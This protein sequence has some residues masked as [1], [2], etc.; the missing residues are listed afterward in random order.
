MSVE[1]L[2]PRQAARSHAG[3]VAQRRLAVFSSRAL[4]GAGLRE[5]APAG[6]WVAARVLTDPVQ[7]EEA[8]EG[9]LDAVLI[10]GSADD[11]PAAAELATRHRCVVVAIVDDP[12]QRGDLLGLADAALLRDRVDRAT[13]ALALTAIDTGLRVIAQELPLRATAALV[14]AERIDPDARAA[15]ALNMLAAGARDADIA[16]RLHLSES[17]ARKLVQRA[18]HQL[19]ARTR[20]E[21]VVKAVV[22]GQLAANGPVSPLRR[23]EP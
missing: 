6:W 17:A 12:S 8:L 3:V 16:V 10:D 18:V 20:C 2:R 14:E 11:A 23:P 13:L 9:G 19:G 1:Q 4:I 7:L 21:A 15:E 22:Q 5:L